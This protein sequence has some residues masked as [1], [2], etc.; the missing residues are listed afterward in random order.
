MNTLRRR[1]AIKQ[2]EFCNP[3]SS[4]EHIKESIKLPFENLMVAS[5]LKV[6]CKIVVNITSELLAVLSNEVICFQQLSKNVLLLFVNEKN[7]F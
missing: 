3:P 2:Y 4:T 6:S 1:I 7:L 5:G